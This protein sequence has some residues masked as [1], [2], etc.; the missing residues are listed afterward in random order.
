[1]IRLPDVRQL[2]DYDCGRAALLAVTHYHG[3]PVLSAMCNPVQGLAPDSIEAE[4]RAECAGAPQ[5][6]FL[7]HLGWEGVRDLLVSSRFLVLP[8]EW[9]E[10]NPLS[11]IEALALGTPVLG[12]AIG[13]IPELVEPGRTGELFTPGDA[14]DLERKLAA[15]WT[16]ALPPLPVDEL[17]ATFSPE[18]YLA[19]LLPLYEGRA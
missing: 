12:A 18:R 1:M 10:N 9:Y 14:D 5:I 17:V 19:R 4:L 6:E 15:L 3:R 2:E 11:A 8:S 16:Q 13:G 7:G